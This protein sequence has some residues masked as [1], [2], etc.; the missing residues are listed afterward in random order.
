MEADQ[1]RKVLVAHDDPLLA[2]GLTAAFRGHREFDVLLRGSR[3]V[4][5]ADAIVAD[6]ENGVRYASTKRELETPVMIVS[7]EDGEAAIREALDAGVRGY[8]L[9]G[10]PIEVIVNSVR[11]MLRGG[12]VIDP[13]AASKMLRS[14]NAE[15]ITKRELAV[16]QLLMH[17]LSDKQMASRLG[18][19]LGTVKCH[20]KRLRWKLKASNRTEAIL[21]AQHRGLVPRVRTEPS[22]TTQS[23]W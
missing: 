2:A 4:K 6:Y 20:L 11:A 19:A 16:L 15:P 21:I 5:T 9:I 1:K 13:V 18:I 23:A 14:L 7:Q 3:L 22:Q 17:G 10:S 8:L 12:F